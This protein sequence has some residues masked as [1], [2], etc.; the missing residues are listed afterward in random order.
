MSATTAADLLW[1][2]PGGPKPMTKQQLSDELFRAETR[3]LERTGRE[4]TVLYVAP[5]ETVEAEGLRG[6][7]RAARC[8]RGI[9]C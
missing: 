1:A 4:A 3:F 5:G 9:G 2:L 6:W 8:D 7:S